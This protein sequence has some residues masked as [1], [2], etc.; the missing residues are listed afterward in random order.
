MLGK[1][2]KPAKNVIMQG[3]ILAQLWKNKESLE[4][5]SCRA[6]KCLHCNYIQWGKRSISATVSTSWVV[7]TM[8][9]D[10][11]EYIIVDLAWKSKSGHTMD[12]HIDKYFR[13]HQIH[14]RRRKKYAPRR[15]LLSFNHVIRPSNDFIRITDLRNVGGLLSTS[16]YR[17][18]N[19]VHAVIEP[20]A[21]HLQESLGL[22][23][24]TKCSEECRPACKSLGDLPHTCTWNC[25]NKS[26]KWRMTRLTVFTQVSRTQWAQPLATVPCIP[27][28]MKIGIWQVEWMSRLES[29]KKSSGRTG[30]ILMK[31][32][33]SGT[34]NHCQ[35][36]LANSSNP[37]FD[38]AGMTLQH[39]KLSP[40]DDLH[41][42]FLF[43]KFYR[44]LGGFL[45]FGERQE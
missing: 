26:I 28:S 29:R 32:C 18:A 17:C 15:Q 31:D 42:P 25:E 38:K 24:S 44:L 33:Y 36:Y 4:C 12:M 6:T 23:R 10:C 22:P 45:R 41:L 13:G 11:V 37:N 35:Y 30:C 1:W 21:Y 20:E 2:F 14:L 16:M 19:M 39:L 40:D 8:S 3:S 7:P 34:L 43:S 9:F 27:K 5:T